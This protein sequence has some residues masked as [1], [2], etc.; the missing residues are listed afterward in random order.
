[1]NIK[2][3]ITEEVV[4]EYR[5]VGPVDLLT[6]ITHGNKFKKHMDLVNTPMTQFNVRHSEE[7]IDGD[8]DM[9]DYY[10]YDKKTDNCVGIFSIEMQP[11]QFKNLLKPG[12]KAVTPHMALAPEVQRQGVSTQAYSSF[13]QGGP[14][15]FVT[16]AHTKGASKLWDS[17]VATG[18]NIS[19]YISDET[20]KPVKNPMYHDMRVLGPK[21]RFKLNN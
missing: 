11:Q 9:H 19:F 16:D 6:H 15:V 14:W 17:L 18:N 8:I 20:G 4:D 3:I 7:N 10:L 13:L 12:I 21:D 2:E 1:M 5:I